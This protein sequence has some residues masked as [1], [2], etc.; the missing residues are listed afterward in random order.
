MPCLKKIKTPN[1]SQIMEALGLQYR[2]N[3]DR[4][5]NNNTEFYYNYYAN[6]DQNIEN[7]HGYD[8]SFSISEQF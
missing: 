1:S 4:K 8:I 7:I 3:Y 2:S 5:E 6:D